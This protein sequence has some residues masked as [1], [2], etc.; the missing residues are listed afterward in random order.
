[1]ILVLKYVQNFIKIYKTLHASIFPPP[2]QE[3]SCMKPWQWFTF[4]Y[5]LT[6]VHMCEGGR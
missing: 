5:L 3:K 2:P 4:I 1:M 6:C